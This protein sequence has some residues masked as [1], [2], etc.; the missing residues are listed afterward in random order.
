MPLTMA[1]V[2]VKSRIL[3]ITGRNETRQFLKRLGFT[4]GSQVTVITRLGSSVIV[5][6]KN[7]RI[8]IGKKM[9]NRIMV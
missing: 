8:A 7:S 4:S 5:N 1:P 9:A 3:K 6:V 2:G